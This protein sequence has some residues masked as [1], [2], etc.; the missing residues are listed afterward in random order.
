[1]PLVK[2]KFNQEYFDNLCDWIRKADNGWYRACDRDTDERKYI[3]HLRWYKLKNKDYR[4]VEIK[5][6]RTETE[7]MYDVP[8]YYQFRLGDIFVPGCSVVGF[9]P[10]EIRLQRMARMDKSIQMDLVQ[11]Q[12]RCR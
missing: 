7:K 12:N 8:A 4:Y 11:Y 3:Y 9:L 2:I 1:M 10:E 6:R 5:D